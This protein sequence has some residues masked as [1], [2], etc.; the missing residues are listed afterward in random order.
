MTKIQQQKVSVFFFHFQEQRIYVYNVETAIKVQNCE[1]ILQTKCGLVFLRLFRIL[2]SSSFQ[3]IRDHAF[4]T[5]L[6]KELQ[7]RVQV[8]DQVD[9]T[10]LHRNSFCYNPLQLIRFSCRVRKCLSFLGCSSV[11]LHCLVLFLTTRPFKVIK[12]I[13]NCPSQVALFYRSAPLHS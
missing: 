2:F 9:F 4:I 6:N 3:S 8:H 12:L 10:C 1:N 5:F 13:P 11:R 7:I